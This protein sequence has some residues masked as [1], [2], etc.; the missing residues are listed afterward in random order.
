MTLA[1]KEVGIRI[2]KN[3]RVKPTAL[4]GEE[5]GTKTLR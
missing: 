3:K 1:D 4:T 2:S 5:T